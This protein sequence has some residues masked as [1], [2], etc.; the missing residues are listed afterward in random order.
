METPMT[1]CCVCNH[2]DSYGGFGIPFLAMLC[3]F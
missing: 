1:S 3:K 2:K